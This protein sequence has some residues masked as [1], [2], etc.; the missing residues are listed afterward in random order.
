MEYRNECAR[1]ADV[2]NPAGTAYYRLH[3]DRTN[4]GD[5]IMS[6]RQTRIIV[7]LIYFIFL[8][9]CTAG[10][11]RGERLVADTGFKISKDWQLPEICGKD[12]WYLNN[13]DAPYVDSEG[14]IVRPPINPRFEEAL[15]DEPF[16]SG[17][18]YS[19]VLGYGRNT[20]FKQKMNFRICV[21]ELEIY[22]AEGENIAHQA[23]VSAE[24]EEGEVKKIPSLVDGNKDTPS[25]SDPYA[26]YYIWGSFTLDWGKE[27]SIKRAVIHSGL[28]DKEKKIMCY[29]P[30]KL[31]LQYWKNDRWED[32]PGTMRQGNSGEKIDISFRPIRTKKLRLYI[33]SQHDNS[34]LTFADYLPQNV[35]FDLGLWRYYAGDFH[36]PNRKHLKLFQKIFPYLK[37]RNNFFGFSFSELDNDFFHVLFPKDGLDG[38]GHQANK[39]YK[40]MKQ[41]VPTPTTKEQACNLL[42]QE[43]E[44]VKKA[45]GGLVYCISGCYFSHHA[46]EW[47]AIMEKPEYYNSNDVSFQWDTI[48]TR[49]ASRQYTR[50]WAAYITWYF[51]CSCRSYP[52]SGKKRGHSKGT[53]GVT[54]PHG[55]GVGQSI[56]L[57]KRTLF[58]VYMSGAS[59]VQHEAKPWV[60]DMDSDAVYEISEEG[61]M[62]RDWFDFTRRYPDRG[63]SYTPIG[64]LL[65]WNHGF[66]PRPFRWGKVTWTGLPYQDGDWMIHEVTGHIFPID[67]QG[68]P[69]IERDGLPLV[70]ADKKHPYGDIFDIIIPNPPSGPLSAEKMREYKVLFPVGDLGM[71]KELA[72]EFEKYVASGGTLILNAKQT[73]NYFNE[74]FLGVKITDKRVKAKKIKFLDESREDK[75]CTF[76]FPVVTPSKAKALATD[77]AGHPLLTVNRYGK[78]NLIFTTPDYLLDTNTNLLPLVKYLLTRITE[79]SLPMKVKGSIEYII[80]HKDKSWVVT[81]INNRGVYKEEREYEVIVPEERSQVEI[82]YPGKIKEVKEW[83]FDEKLKQEYSGG[84]TRISLTVPAGDVRI[85]EIGF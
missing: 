47:G 15:K 53:P 56:S 43:F 73:D 30:D 80:N 25:Y 64:I 41:A 52:H 17:N 59:F 10:L 75:T 76:E 7:R 24:C 31:V 6:T 63:I 50:P 60:H 71:S 74:D 13:S 77:G 66:Y 79:E 46:L 16:L 44:R 42:H 40:V 5:H 21:R 22:N 2:S 49:G 82:I 85:V 8:L 14:K 32:V 26:P 54:Y 69:A 81:L 19:F 51:G 38:K 65:D 57:N 4:E 58:L 11:A 55:P 27:E 35:P 28:E 70:N 84:N 83:R 34:N 12:F 20:P 33:H 78:G 29:I 67:E 3:W 37:D 39:W 48:F 9:I 68:Y 62:M 23:N 18:G 72:R 61:K 36:N 1:Q 45:Y